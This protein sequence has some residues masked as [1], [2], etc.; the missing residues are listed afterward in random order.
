MRPIG[1][2][3]DEA[4]ARLFE[5]HLLTLEIRSMVEPSGGNW[6]V[7]IH[8]DRHLER[9]GQE[10]A[11]FR[12]DPDHARYQG[13]EQAA[14]SVRTEKKRKR[15]ASRAQHVDMSHQ[16]QK[17]LASRCPVTL[18]LLVVSLVV[19]ALSSMGDNHGA[20]SGLFI[21]PLK[22]GGNMVSWTV[23]LPTVLQ[24]GQLWRPFTPMFIHFGLLHIVFNMMLL[25]RL[26]PAIETRRGSAWYAAI[27]L[28]ISAGSNVLQYAFVGPYFGGMSGVVYGLFGYIWVKSKC[29]PTDTLYMPQS[30]VFWLMGWFFFCLL[31]GVGNVAN[32]GHGAGLAFGAALGYGSAMMR[33]SRTR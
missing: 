11:E 6:E 14:A 28:T 29:D 17:P 25:W 3:P 15:K 9:A 23:T 8:D 20:L 27:V 18:G 33:Q 13:A 21:L 19:F 22:F 7:W 10:L 16:W 5:D 12:L 30:T 4:Q 2:L 31:G 26:G 1:T 24:Q 32:V